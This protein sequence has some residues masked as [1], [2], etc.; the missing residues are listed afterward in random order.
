MIV[1]LVS[2]FL[3]DANEGKADMPDEV[4]DEACENFRQVLKAT[5][6]PK[7]DREYEPYMSTIGKPLCQQQ[8]EKSGAPKENPTWDFRMKMLIGDMV[9]VAA[10]AIMKGA[11]IP[12]ARENQEVKW[13]SGNGII[14]GKTDVSIE[15]DGVYDIKSASKYQF[16]YKF[17]TGDA[18]NK[19]R[20]DDPFGYLPQG[21]LYGEASGEK[22]RGWIAICKETGEWCVVNPPIADN[23]YK[24]AAIKTAKENAETLAEDKPF[25]RCFEP[26]VEEFR[27]KKTGNKY[28]DTTCSFCPYKTACW[29]EVTYRDQV[30]SKAAYPKKRYY[31]GEVNE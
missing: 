17:N 10:I 29:G 14:R 26:I 30:K 12:V 13:D 28:L 3:S 15:G 18:F 1:E 7:K 24:K 23:S 22:F 9:E 5:F 19:L 31:V 20:E 4:I 8:M 25:K 16:N 6:K 27:G 21:Y 2:R 11:G